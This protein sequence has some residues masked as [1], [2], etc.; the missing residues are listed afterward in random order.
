MR[1]NC[2]VSVRLKRR[3]GPKQR[4]V[5]NSNEPTLM[6]QLEEWDWISGDV[7]GSLRH[8]SEALQVRFHTAHCNKASVTIES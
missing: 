6:R 1:E 8:T 4:L 2:D 7:N 5:H 3:A